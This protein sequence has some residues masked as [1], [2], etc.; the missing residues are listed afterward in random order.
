MLQSVVERV[1]AGPSAARSAT[2]ISDSAGEQ[3]AVIR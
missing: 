2:G 1:V 3:A